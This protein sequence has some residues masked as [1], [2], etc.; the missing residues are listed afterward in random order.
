MTVAPPDLILRGVPGGG[1]MRNLSSG[2][3]VRW[4]G[5]DGINGGNDDMVML[6]LKISGD[7]KDFRQNLNFVYFP[8]WRRRK[9][10][11]V[12][13]AEKCDHNRPLPQSNSASQ[14][15]PHSIKV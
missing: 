3:S 5:V 13:R 10:L 14:Y 1:V 12:E 11:S 4:A 15:L 7:G 8:K 2:V 9:T 6:E